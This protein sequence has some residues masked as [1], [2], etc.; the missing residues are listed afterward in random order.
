M[1]VNN[2]LWVLGTMVVVVAVAAMGWFFGISPKLDEASAN[3]S[4]RENVELQND[5]QE[6]KLIQIKGEYERI[7]EVSAELA[8]MRAVVPSDSDLST[9][10]GELHALEQKSKVAITRIASNDGVPYVAP[11]DPNLDAAMTAANA[12][13]DPD[14]KKAAVEKAQADADAAQGPGRGMIDETNLV[15]IPIDIEVKGSRAQVVDFVN[16]LQNGSRLYLVTKLN[17]NEET[18]EA[19]PVGD[20]DAEEPLPVAT[21]NYTGSIAG[22]VYVLLDP[23][24]TAA[25]AE[26]GTTA[27]AASAPKG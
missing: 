13:T 14:E 5:L 8:A 20:E 16:S 12:L 15:L 18:P 26:E 9:F 1:Q 3:D 22:F 2:R 23:N 21:V 11:P 6:I 17:I 7:D 27:E 25:A 24:G 4:D 10:I 19:E